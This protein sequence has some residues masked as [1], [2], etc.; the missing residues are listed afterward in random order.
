MSSP[1]SLAASGASR[2]R[3]R[4]A[5]RSSSPSSRGASKR[6]LG[7]VALPKRG[8]DSIAAAASA[9]SLS[10]DSAAS[11]QEPSRVV[12]VGSLLVSQSHLTAAVHRPLASTNT[13]HEARRLMYSN[14]AHRLVSQ[15][16][17]TVKDR[18]REYQLARSRKRYAPCVT[19]Y[20][21]HRESVPR[22]LLRYV[23]TPYG[24]TEA[25]LSA[26][27]VTAH[28]STDHLARFF[29]RLHSD[30]YDEE[31]LLSASVPMAHLQSVVA[32]IFSSPQCEYPP[33]PRRARG[34]SSVAASSAAYAPLRSTKSA[35]A[36]LLALAP[37]I[38]SHSLSSASSMPEQSSLSPLPS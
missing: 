8:H 14:F 5:E 3:K 35:A 37:A 17:A 24:C 1:S 22:S 28:W 4:R 23:Y 19:G 34:P 12:A 10:T 13:G 36:Q 16:C 33:R 9:E 15:R 26:S 29:S 27:V 7:P 31:T 11:T 25:D 32:D 21:K 20:R 18:E 38:A 30:G 2:T 6:Q